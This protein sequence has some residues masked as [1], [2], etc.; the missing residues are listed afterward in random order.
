MIIQV[1]VSTM[2]MKGVSTEANVSPLRPLPPLLLSS[3]PDMRGGGRKHNREECIMYNERSVL[4]KGRLYKIESTTKV[5]ISKKICS[6]HASDL[7]Y[8]K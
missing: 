7:I 1:N 2:F 4:N 3:E 6:R 8:M 5:L